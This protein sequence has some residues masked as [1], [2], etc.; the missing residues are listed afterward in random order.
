MRRKSAAEE[1]RRLRHA[2]LDTPGRGDGDG[3]GDGK[4]GARD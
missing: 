3:D 2:D 4:R 1:L